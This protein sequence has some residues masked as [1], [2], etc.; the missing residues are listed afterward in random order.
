MF[1]CL[2][3]KQIKT[4][5]GKKMSKYTYKQVLLFYALLLKLINPVLRIFR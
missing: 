4:Q 2:K 1:T 5:V 3:Y